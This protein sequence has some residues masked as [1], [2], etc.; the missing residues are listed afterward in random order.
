MKKLFKWLFRLVLVL[1]ILILLLIVFLDPIARVVAERLVKE[2]TGMETRI[3]KVRVG[4]KS[5]SLAIENLELI[6]SAEFGGSRFL[7]VPE[8]RVDYDIPAL[9]DSKIHLTLVRFN[10]GEMHI[11]QSKDG[12]TNVRALQ[13]RQKQKSSSTEGSSTSKFGFQGI[14]ALTLTIGRL[15]FTSEK[16]S[17]NDTEVYVGIKNETIKNVKSVDDLKPLVMRI[18]LEKNANFLPQSIFGPGTNLIENATNSAGK[19]AQKALDGA[20][21]QLKKN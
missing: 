7:S 11:V 1:V 13:E 6:N 19:E 9:R 21:D 4:L 2:Q 18:A 3:G 20:T 12:R 16:N 10:L 15:K 8:L 17:T 5:P 14:D